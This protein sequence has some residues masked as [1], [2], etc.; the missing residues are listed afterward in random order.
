MF[1]TPVATVTARVLR[2]KV[3]TALNTPGSLPPEIQIAV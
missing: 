3:S 1:T 2:S